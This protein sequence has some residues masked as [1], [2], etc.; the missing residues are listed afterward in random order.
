MKRKKIVIL[1]AG[2]SGLATAY[3]F[4]KAK[5]NIPVFEKET[6]AGG[7][8]R[9]IKKNG[10]TFD[11]SGHLLHFR[12]K[13]LLSLVKGLL[14]NNLKQHSR[15][16]FV[17]SF[18]RFIPYPF[19]TNLHYLPK[20]ISDKCLMDFI[21]ARNNGKEIKSCGSFLDW[22]NTKFG[23]AISNHFMAPYNEKFWRRPLDDLRH[24][25]TDRFVVVPSI[26]EISNG[27]F[28]KPSGNIGYSAYFYYPKNGGIEE[29]IKG[30]SSSLKS[31]Y[32]KHWAQEINLKKS[33]R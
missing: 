27:F 4:K 25:W 32:L 11:F 31:I 16:S 26:V 14:A 7:L 23:P 3:F 29:L 30:F 24:E 10:F 1:G 28:K 2:L 19:Q 21:E 15:R 6:E 22:I 8:C 13:K 33:K 18:N 5:Q 12:D 9:S 20:G 17:Y